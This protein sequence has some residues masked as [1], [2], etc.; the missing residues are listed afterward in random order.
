MYVYIYIHLSRHKWP[1][2]KCALP[3]HAGAPASAWVSGF[4][5]RDSGFGFL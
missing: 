1:G 5:F 4:G 3:D 2:L